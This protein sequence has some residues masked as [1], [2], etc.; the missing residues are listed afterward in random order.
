MRA[1]AGP[2]PELVCGSRHEPEH[3]AHVWSLLEPE[4]PVLTQIEIGH[5]RYSRLNTD[6]SYEN[7]VVAERDGVVIWMM[8]GY[9]MGEPE[10]E[11]DEPD[12]VLEPYTRLEAPG[13]FYISGMA[14]LPEHRSGGLGSRM[15][16]IAAEWA[17]EMELPEL[18]LI[19]FE[20]NEGAV[21]RNERTGLKWSDGGF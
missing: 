13:S 1:Q 18:S 12:T 16:E 8:H 21:R 19:S 5:R 20:Q 10:P 14:V 7:C 11:D 2:K 15:L 3:R 17:Q 6:L 9:R 4:Y